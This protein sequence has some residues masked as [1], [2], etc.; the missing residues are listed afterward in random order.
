MPLFHASMCQVRYHNDRALVT[1]EESRTRE[2]A[3]VGLAYLASV[4]VQMDNC[5]NLP[6]NT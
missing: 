1:Q 6:G 5:M 2:F 3:V 4:L